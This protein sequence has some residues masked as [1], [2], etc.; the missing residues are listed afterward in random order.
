M[1]DEFK[2]RGIT[3][4]V[5]DIKRNSDNKI[6]AIN[7]L[8][9]SENGTEKRMNLNQIEPIKAIEMYVNQLQNGKWDFGIKQIKN[10]DKGGDVTPN[11][12]KDD[13]VITSIVKICYN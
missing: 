5:S 6:I 8:M 9:K 10:I 1:K 7:I 4:N 12:A 11:E 2:D 3:I 13:D